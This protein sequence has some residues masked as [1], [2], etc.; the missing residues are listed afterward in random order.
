MVCLNL[1]DANFIYFAMKHYTN[2]QCSGIEE[3]M[4]DLSHIKY[5]KRLLRR[6]EDNGEIQTLKVRLVLNHLI[7]LFNVFGPVATVRILFLKIDQSCWSFLKTFLVFL[8][9]MPMEIEA[10]NGKKIIS[11]SIPIDYKIQEELN[12]V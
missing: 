6:Y 8:S 5:L 1:T 11:S 12:N 2:P 7:L 4:D 10:I 9:Y 3:F